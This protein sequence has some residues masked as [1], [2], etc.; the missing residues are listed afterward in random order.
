MA[1]VAGRST[2][3]L[4][5]I[6]KITTAAGI[7]IVAVVAVLMQRVLFRPEAEAVLA[8]AKG[9]AAQPSSSSL[10]GKIVSVEEP[11]SKQSKPGLRRATV[12]LNS[13]ETV[14]A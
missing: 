3:T 2:G 5:V 4:A 6:V 1:V 13:G 8:P 9:V 11:S 10:M 12:K 7:I 14:Q